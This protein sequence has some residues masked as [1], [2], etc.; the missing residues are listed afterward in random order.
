MSVHEAILNGEVDFATA[1]GMADEVAASSGI[2]IDL[3]SGER[4]KELVGV[5]FL[6]VGGT[7]REKMA[8]G[9]KTDFVT[10]AA[11]VADEATLKKRHISL[12]GKSFEPG[13]IVGFNDGSTGVRRQL[14]NYLH[15]AKHI[16]VVSDNVE[17]VESGKRGDCTYDKLVGEWTD[18]NT[19]EISQREDKEGNILWTWEFLLP[20]G[21][22]ANRGLRTSAY[23]GNFG[24]DTTTKYLA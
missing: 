14:V 10:V 16:Q 12:A 19:G 2:D 17:V 23:K 8:E 18:H 9:K 15:L 3:F 21:L 24:K 1:A 13:T 4:L 5:P 20:K 6:I 22:M 11:F 7:F